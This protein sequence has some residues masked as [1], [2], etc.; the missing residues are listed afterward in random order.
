[1]TMPVS[2]LVASHSVDRGTFESLYAGPAPW[3][4]GK[5]PAAVRRDR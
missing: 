5:A 2:T 1:M 4:I 3:D